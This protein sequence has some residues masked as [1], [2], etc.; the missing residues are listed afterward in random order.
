MC[1]NG[2]FYAGETT[3]VRKRLRQHRGKPGR[4]AATRF[5]GEPPVYCT[6]GID[7]FRLCFPVCAA[8]R[9][10]NSTAFSAGAYVAF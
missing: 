1:G 2:L 10:L 5:R 9:P 3:C 7:C 8:Q 4:A 6:R